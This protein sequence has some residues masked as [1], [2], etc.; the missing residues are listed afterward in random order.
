VL[1]AHPEGIEA[2]LV[3]VR[4]PGPD[5]PATVAAL[6]GVRPGLP[7]CLMSGAADPHDPRVLAAGCPLLPK[8]FGLAELA[9]A[10]RALV[11]GG[12]NPAEEQLPASSGRP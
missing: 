3:D 11:A 5:G 4:L 8:P 6:R 2:A 1:R 7:C 9:R 12:G 10:L